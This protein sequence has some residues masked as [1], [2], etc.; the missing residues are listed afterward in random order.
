MNDSNRIKSENR[1]NAEI[2]VNSAKSDPWGI[3]NVKTQPFFENIDLK[4]FTHIHRQAFFPISSVFVS[5][6]SK[7]FPEHF[8]STF[9]RLNFKNF[10]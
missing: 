1:K 2:P 9:M 4:L 8:F 3:Q 10:Q 7:T 6:K 5:E